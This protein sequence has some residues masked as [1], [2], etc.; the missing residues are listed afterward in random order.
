VRT[1]GRWVANALV[2]GVLLVV[3]TPS[4]VSALDALLVPALIA[5]AL[6]FVLRLLWYWTSL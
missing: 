5:V 3:L 4:V 6:I 1:L 2:A